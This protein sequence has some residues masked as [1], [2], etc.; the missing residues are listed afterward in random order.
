MTDYKALTEAIGDY[1]TGLINDFGGGNVGWWQDYMRA[2]IGRANDHWRTAYLELWA[3]V[4]ELEEAL[5]SIRQYGSD[6]LSGRTDGPDDRN[7][8][9][10]A[11]LEMTKRAD[12]ALQP[13]E[14]TN[15]H[16]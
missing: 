12:A 6:T 4:Q 5:D 8:Q 16:D 13:P 7:W 2:E 14:T 3:R 15:D 1:D 11:V 9:R 10:G